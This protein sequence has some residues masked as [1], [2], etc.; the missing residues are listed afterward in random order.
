M[1]CVWGGG[2]LLALNLQRQ[3]NY[4]RTG[5]DSVDLSFV[6]DVGVIKARVFVSIA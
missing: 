4:I 1:L 6:I 5:V 2:E 3:F